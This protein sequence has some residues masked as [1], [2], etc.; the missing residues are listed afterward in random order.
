MVGEDG[1]IA[2]SLGS[3][4]SDREEPEV[5]TTKEDAEDDEDDEDD[6]TD[7]SIGND[8]PTT[9]ASAAKEVGLFILLMFV[10]CF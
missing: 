6:S 4:P 10:Y 2:R 3:K 9:T 8:A 1:N 5:T 7:D